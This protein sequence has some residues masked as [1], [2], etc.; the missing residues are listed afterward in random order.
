MSY[1]IIRL[2][3]KLVNIK[4]NGMKY[5]K[6]IMLLSVI[7][8]LL[9]GCDNP[10]PTQ[11]VS[12]SA[13]QNQI[14]V[15][16]ITKDTSNVYYDNGFDTTGVAQPTLK[17]SNTIT[18]TGTKVTQNGFT[19]SSGYAQAMFFDISNPITDP[20]GKVLGYM[21]RKFANRM[22]SITFDGLRALP[23]PYSLRYKYNGM[24]IDTLLGEQFVLIDRG[25]MPGRFR[26]RYGSQINCKISTID[27]AV[28]FPIPTPAEIT[29][30]VT[31]T[32]HLANKNISGVVQWNAGNTQSVE[33][34]IGVITRNDNS[35][36]PL[37]Q[38]ELKDKGRLTIPPKLLNEIPKNRYDKF[39][40]TLV[41]KIEFQKYTDN[42]NL[43]I[44]SQ[45]IHSIILDIP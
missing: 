34:I 25:S 9:F 6:F 19:T 5:F 41:R 28:E 14:Q 4:L 10:A 32:G 23:V 22:F 40:F 20:S 21:T 42:Q 24:N 27:S 8:V 30:K 15:E 39:V 29:G 7:A 44:L 37:Y 33:L 35:K 12:D 2:K 11:L 43:Y 17:Y 16:V 31:L 1:V 45:S 36:Y 3:I 26:Y 13:D 18:L 38:L